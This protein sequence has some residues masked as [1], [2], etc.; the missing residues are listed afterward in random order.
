MTA[1]IA[2]MPLV[3][4]SSENKIKH[5]VKLEREPDRKPQYLWLTEKTEIL[6]FRDWGGKVRIMTSLCPHMGAQLVIR[7]NSLF[8]PWHGLAFSLDTMKSTHHRYRQGCEHR[9]DYIDGELVIYE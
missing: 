7:N 8:C 1:T 9:G 6:V 3:N 2:T 4:E 5:R